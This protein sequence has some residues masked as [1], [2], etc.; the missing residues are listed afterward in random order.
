MIYQPGTLVRTRGRNWIVMPSPDDELL[1]IKPLGGGEDESCAI[2][3]PLALDDERVEP[4]VFPPPS[5]SDIGDISSARLLY[6]AIRLSFRNG[7]GP[8]RCLAQLSFRPRSYQMVPLI[9]AL[10]F[11]D[12]P[13]RM[14]IADDVGVGKTIEGLLIV[15]ELLERREIDRFAVICLPHLCDQWQKELEEKFGIEA[16]IIRSSTQARLDREIRGDESVFRYYP[17]QVISIDYI[18]S[19]HRRAVFVNEC[20]ELVLVDEAHSC[21]RPAGASRNQMQR[22]RLIRD[23]ADKSSQGLILL[24]ATPHSGK[25]EEFRSLLGLV[26]SDFEGWDPTT[27]GEDLKR[28]LARQFVQRRRG[29]VETWHRERSEE[30]TP[31]PKRDP[32]EY[33]YQLS[34]SYQS[35]FEEMYD[36]VRSMALAGQG[37]TGSRGRARY[38]TALSLLRGIMSSPAAGVEMLS[39]RIERLSESAVEANDIEIGEESPLSEDES[40]GAGDT[41]PV[42][43]MSQAGLT[44]QEQQRLKLLA[45]ELSA[46]RSFDQDWKLKHTLEIVQIWLKDG[47]STIIFCRFIPTANYVGRMLAA[48]LK[49]SFPDVDVQAVTS[50]DPDDI[51]KERIAAMSSSKLRILVATDCLS[52]GINLQELFTGVLHY[53][54]PWNPNRLEQREGRVDRFGQRA[55]VVRAFLLYGADNPVDGVVLK[56]LINKVREIRKSTGISIPFPENSQSLLE[57]V[58]QAV[59]FRS[60]PQDGRDL[61]RSLDLEMPRMAELQTT[62]EIEQAAEREKASRTIFAQRA[63]RAEEIET[64]LTEADR[65]IGDPKDVER[66]TL[67]VLRALFGVEVRDGKERGDYR[68]RTVN[69]PDYLREDLLPQAEWVR[70]SFRS[71]TPLGH[72]YVGRNHRFV[73]ELC[74]Y[75]TA[76]AFEENHE[77]A[78]SRAAVIR[79]NA[80]QT[81]TTIVLLRARNVIED[82]AKNTRL[83]AEEILAHGYR[84]SAAEL[85]YINADDATKL[86]GEATASGD[87]SGPARE[88]AL[89]REI[90]ELMSIQTHTD[91][92]AIDRAQHLVEQH[93]RYR[94]VLSK[95]APVKSKFRAVEPILPMDIVGLYVLLPAIGDS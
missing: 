78:V 82:V 12:D 9:M 48:E 14:L 36:F 65:A 61:Q 33:A 1:M 73:E 54:L 83:V 79:T 63:I 70:I 7:G 80:V 18:K 39:H 53:D 86:I 52:E 62:R 17:Y 25:G 46:L 89:N 10:R 85:E 21:T 26:D 19:D 27:A 5:T 15:K 50:E 88:A 37:E 60:G 94:K 42:G 41:A 84:G 71:P 93:E 66:F 23:I 44:K 3:L 30:R 40:V 16:V 95:R 45:G 31:F 34:P 67:D 77:R 68:L 59:L 11:A 72:V 28:R 69:I 6:N 24:T 76:I 91:K 55:S 38:W 74:Q 56:V 32:G 75:V 4:A 35:F 87:L 57:A 29:D 81:K 8:F 92:I 49:K 64:D 51:R 13:V 43:M 58:M 22:H 47:F 20:P 2:Y 90:E